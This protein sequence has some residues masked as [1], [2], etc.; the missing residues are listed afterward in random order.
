MRYDIPENVSQ[1]ALQKAA[2]IS[3]L[4]KQWV[5]P[6]LDWSVLT[7]A[8]LFGNLGDVET[9]KLVRKKIGLDK[10]IVSVIDRADVGRADA[11][12][13]SHDWYQKIYLYI[14]LFFTDSISNNQQYIR[15]RL[16]IILSENVLA[17]LSDMMLNMED[18][19]LQVFLDLDVKHYKNPSV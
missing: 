11:I 14:D 10:Y 3:R 8:M 18:R 13:L 6:D 2:S 15:K 4:R 7:R 9:T 1:K 19:E 17:S 12:L 16:E 5:G